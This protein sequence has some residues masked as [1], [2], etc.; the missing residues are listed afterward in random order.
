MKTSKFVKSLPYI[1]TALSIVI[2]LSVYAEDIK[3]NDLLDQLGYD[4]QLF[5]EGTDYYTVI[6][7]YNESV[8]RGM[9]EGFSPVLVPRSE[10]TDRLFEQMIED[11][12]S[13]HE[14]VKKEVKAEDGKR[15]LEECLE[16]ACE[17]YEEEFTLEDL[18]GEYD[19]DSDIMDFPISILDFSDDLQVVETI[20]FEVPTQN[21]WEIVACLESDFWNNHPST[22]MMMA[23]CRYWYEKY[24]AVPVAIS[25]DILEMRV[26]E[27]IP[28]SEALELAKEH[29]A[30]T[31][32][33][34]YQCTGAGTLSEVADSLKN[35]TVWYFWWD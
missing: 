28:E 24:Q 3:K 23:V 18:I 26:S 7:A 8:K 4:Y 20:L 9:I 2:S 12:Y 25:E 19:G 15:Y 32:D 29:F 1:S 30:F 27:P 33:R 21:P 6:Q 34:V 5:E 22:E 11:E 16:A 17:I 10:I 35:S 13:F 31:P 14:M